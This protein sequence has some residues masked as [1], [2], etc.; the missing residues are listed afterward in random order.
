VE[1]AD[2]LARTVREQVA[3]GRLLPLGGP[4]DPVW[5]TEQAAV[6]ALRRGCAGL[7]GVR[8]GTVAVRLDAGDG[9]DGAPPEPPDGDSRAAGPDAAPPGALPH[10]PLRITAA[11]EASVA[12]PL[13]AAAERLRAALFGAA[14]GGLGLDVAVVDLEVAG[15]L[16]EADAGNGA[17]VPDG[18]AGPP[19]GGRPRPPGHQGEPVGLLPGTGSG[20]AGAVEAAV[21]A[22]PGVV[23]LAGVPAGNGGLQVRDTRPPQPPGRRVRVQLAAV[24]GHHAL[25]VGRLAADAARAA[26]APGAPGP[27][28]A[29]VLVTSA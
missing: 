7:P 23:G 5:I 14:R 11:F 22:V 9:A 24:P 27:V 1:S 16:E 8:L 2:R 20:T 17:R 18:S 15:L 6:L 13:P 12:E 21:R 29:S 4:G 25:T 19:A 3:L 10:G 28:A 26:A